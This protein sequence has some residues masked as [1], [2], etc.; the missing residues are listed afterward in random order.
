MPVVCWWFAYDDPGD[1]CGAA[2]G[3]VS[4]AGAGEVEI[5]KSRRG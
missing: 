3:T 4:G 2:G 1:P 5:G